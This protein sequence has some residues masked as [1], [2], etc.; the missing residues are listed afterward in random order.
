MH[1][2]I[3]HS[4]RACYA[5]GLCA[6]CYV[7]AHRT[8]QL[9][10]HARKAKQT[11]GERQAK[12]RAYRAR[13][14]VRLRQAAYQETYRD[15]RPDK[16]LKDRANSRRYKKQNPHVVASY[17]QCR[18]ARLLNP[19]SPGVSPVEWREILIVFGHACAYCL[20]TVKLT[21]DHVLPLSRGGLDEPDNVVPACQPCNSRKG[22]GS[23]L[24]FV[25][26]KKA[27]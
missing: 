2:A 9:G 26:L 14:D 11:A 1:P 6:S 22:A 24:N 3:C 27:G 20:R 21:R 16:R 12:Q 17:T 23:L 4:A 7:S 10:A 25:L 18:R 19:A 15:R 5:R 13:L 8:G